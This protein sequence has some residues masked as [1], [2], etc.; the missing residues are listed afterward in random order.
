MKLLSTPVR[1]SRSPSSRLL[2]DPKICHTRPT[3]AIQSFPIC[4]I[5]SATG[6][7]YV[8]FYGSTQYCS[9]HHWKEFLRPDEQNRDS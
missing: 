8:M 2:P 6:C 3:G 7:P 9:N 1:E 5:G 4:L